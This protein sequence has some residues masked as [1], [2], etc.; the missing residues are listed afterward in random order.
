MYIY[1]KNVIY[2]KLLNNSKITYSDNLT[3]TEFNQIKKER[4]CY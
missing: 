2:E 4:G 1:G 3:G